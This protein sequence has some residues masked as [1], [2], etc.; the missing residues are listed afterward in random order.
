MKK[1]VLT[2]LYLG[3]AAIIMLQGCGIYI[4]AWKQKVTI[5]AGTKGSTIKYQGDSVGINTAKI[6]VRKTNLFQ[7]VSVEKSGFKSKNYAF[8]LKGLTPMFAISFLDILMLGPVWEY[9]LPNMHKY[10]KTQQ[11]PALLPL[12]PRNANEKYL[13]VENTSID[14]KGNDFHFVTYPSISRFERKTKSPY[15]EKKK[16]SRGNFDDLKVENTIFTDEL[17]YTLK[18]MNFI[19][20][21]RTVFPNAANSLFVDASIKKITFHEVR[22]KEEKFQES[23]QLLSMELD[24]E[25][26]LLDYYKQPLYTTHTFNK[27]DLFVFRYYHADPGYSVSHAITKAIQDNLEY[28]LLTLRKELSSK[29]LLAVGTGASKID[30]L[31]VLAIQRPASETNMRVNDMLRSTVSVKVSDGHGS[32]VIISSDGYIVTNYH[33][34]AGTKEIE[35]IFN[36]GSKAAGEIVRRNPDADL[37]LIK[38]KK[39]SLRPLLI[40]EKT[41]PEIGIEVWAIGTPKSLELGQSVSKGIISGIRKANEMS[42][43]QTDV[44]INPGNSGGPL[45]SKDGTVLGIITSKLMG[46]GTEG[47]G[48]AIM[49][50]EILSKLKLKYQ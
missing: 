20:T 44:K 5:V 47:V 41:E 29:N 9:K 18:K 17:N 39:D 37:A 32:G 6:K 36:D 38:V 10:D 35:I 48:F 45:V 40:S 8:Q 3:V 1:P 16:H 25:W 7:A 26:K 14:T 21:T 23:N 2:L 24:I 50:P 34:I 42:Y 43:L 28:A 33:V 15:V 27:S 12:E 30:T 4:P 19:D 49:S 22:F 46:F 11:A 13:I 31:P